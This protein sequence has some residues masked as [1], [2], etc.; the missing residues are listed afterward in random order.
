MTGIG[1]QVLVLQAQRF[2]T[3]LS[4]YPGRLLVELC[5]NSD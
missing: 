2:T 5:T 3:E 1:T 4:R